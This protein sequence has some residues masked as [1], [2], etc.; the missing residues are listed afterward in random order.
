M[1][2]EVH[3]R[4]VTPA[5]DGSGAVDVVADG[6]LYVD[7]LREPVGSKSAS[8]TPTIIEISKMSPPPKRC[9]QE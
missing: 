3:I 1:D 5:M 8:R 7:H 9:A 6:F 2:A 4:S